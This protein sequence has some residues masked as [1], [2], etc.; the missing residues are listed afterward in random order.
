MHIV[1]EFLVQPII[2]PGELWL[3]TR[4]DNRKLTIKGQQEAI[5]SFSR[6][7]THFTFSS[8]H[9]FPLQSQL[10]ASYPKFEENSDFEYVL[11]KGMKPN[12]ASIGTGQFPVE[13][14]SQWESLFGPRMEKRHHL[15]RRSE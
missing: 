3:Q 12:I 4:V 8:I 13:I 15:P 11:H 10:L 6:E 1:L 5:S 7:S 2:T 9:F 14:N